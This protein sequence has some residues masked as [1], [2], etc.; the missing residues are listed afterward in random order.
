[1]AAPASA[2]QHETAGHTILYSV[3]ATDQLNAEVARRYGIERSDRRGLLTV[4]V[5]RKDAA[6]GDPAV[7][8]RI[9]GTVQSLLGEPQTLRFQE[10]RGEDAVDYL[11]TFALRRPDTLRFTLDVTPEG[12]KAETIRFQREFPAD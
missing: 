4:I 9:A 7:A 1:M 12:G 5:R 10:V 2:Q 6:A 3:L 8:A 11:A